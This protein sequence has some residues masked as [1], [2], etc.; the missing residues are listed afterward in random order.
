MSTITQYAV[1]NHAQSIG[2]QLQIQYQLDMKKQTVEKELNVD[3]E[4]YSQYGKQIEQLRQ[5]QG[6]NSE[7]MTVLTELMAKIE[8][9]VKMRLGLIKELN[10]LLAINNQLIEKLKSADPLATVEFVSNFSAIQTSIRNTFGYVRINNQAVSEQRTEQSNSAAAA[11]S[12]QKELSVLCDM[13]AFA[14]LNN[15]YDLRFVFH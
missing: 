14:K 6:G 2:K 11:A 4:L 8:S 9:E 12:Y 5:E 10:N 3:Y 13:N 15:G 7:E 1:L